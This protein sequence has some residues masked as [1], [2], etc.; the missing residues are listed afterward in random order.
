MNLAGPV[1]TT[2]TKQ[3]MHVAKLH[4]HLLTIFR[5]GH[6]LSGRIAQGV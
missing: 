5:F 6:K 3:N 4:V 2:D 1:Y